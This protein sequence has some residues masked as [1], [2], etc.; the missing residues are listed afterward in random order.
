MADLNIFRV[1]LT[2]AQETP[3]TSSAA[4]GTGEVEWDLGDKTLTYSFAVSGLDFGPAFGQPPS[5]LTTADDVTGM[6]FHSG[7]R[8]VAGPIAFGQLG[9]AQDADDL[10]VT[11]NVGGSWTVRG[12]W[13]TTDPATIPIANFA[14]ALDRFEFD[15]DVP[16]YW[17]VHTAAFSNG[18]IRGQLVGDYQDNYY[19]DITVPDT[20]FADAF[21]GQAVRL[22]DT[23][24]DRL[25]DK[26]GLDYWTGHLRAGMPLLTV[27]DSFTASPEFQGRYGVPDNKQFVSLLYQNVLDRSGE[28]QGLVYWQSVLDSNQ[29]TRAQV[30]V[31]FS[32]SAEHVAMVEP[33]DYL[34]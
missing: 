28:Q 18:A 17:D 27:A 22:Y 13:E 21:Q 16:L 20:T 3:P 31:G 9:P 4:S 2:S 12:V 24:F 14:A 1:T 30:V 34:L 15:L 6:H 33:G 29:A 25:P 23:V 11:L 32:E 19:A 10:K 26:G 7:A 8:G 5:T